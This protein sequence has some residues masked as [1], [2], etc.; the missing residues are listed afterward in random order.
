MGCCDIPNLY[1]PGQYPIAVGEEDMDLYPH[2]FYIYIQKAAQDR[3]IL[4]KKS[5]A[6]LGYFDFLFSFSILFFYSTEYVQ[7][8]NDKTFTPPNFYPL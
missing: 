4:I 1:P 5:L 7:Q 8:A 6:L 3:Q 2:N